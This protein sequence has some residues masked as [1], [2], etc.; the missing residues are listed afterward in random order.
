LRTRAVAV[1]AVLL[2]PGAAAER[3]GGSPGPEAPQDRRGL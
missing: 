2:R 3:E 1:L